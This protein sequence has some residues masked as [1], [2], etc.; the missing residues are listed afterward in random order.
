VAVKLSDKN[1]E[2]NTRLRRPEWLKVNLGQNDDFAH[3]R[4]LIQRQKL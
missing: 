1:I 2:A 3:V 4:R